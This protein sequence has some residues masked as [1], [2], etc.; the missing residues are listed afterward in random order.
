MR[1]R[2][3]RFT[4][5]QLR[6]RIQLFTLDPH[7]STCCGSICKSKCFMVRNW[8]CGSG[9]Q[10]SSIGKN[11]TVN[12]LYGKNFE[13]FWNIAYPSYYLWST[14][15][16]L[17]YVR[18]LWLSMCFGSKSVQSWI[19]EMRKLLG[20]T[21]VPYH[22]IKWPLT[23]LRGPGF[24]APCSCRAAAWW[25]SWSSWSRGS[26]PSR[27]DSPCS[28]LL[29]PLHPGPAFFTEC[30]SVADPECFSRNRVVLPGFRIRILTFY[31]SRIQGSKRHRIPDPDPQ[32][33]NVP[34]IVLDMWI[35][36]RL[37]QHSGFGLEM[38]IQERMEIDQN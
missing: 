35:R 12:I 18:R 29:S 16:Y 34:D 6:V 8:E 4:Y 7:H 20:F 14:G 23:C 24:A 36:I 26:E 33:W 32:H 22:R 31:P 9:S 3:Q 25:R 28:Q 17:V 30:S 15:Q 37:I 21:R 5:M 13:F 10:W 38:R 1:V 11:V 2:I 19:F 27:P